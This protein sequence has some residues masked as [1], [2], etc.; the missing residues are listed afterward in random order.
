MFGVRDCVRHL[1]ELAGLE[2]GNAGHCQ[3]DRAI[4]E[5]MVKLRNRKQRWCPAAARDELCQGLAEHAHLLLPY[6]VRLGDIPA[7]GE[8]DRIAEG[9]PPENSYSNRG[10]DGFVYGASQFAA[11]TLP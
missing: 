8:E 3:V 9:L 6:P 11:G 7:F 1:P 10:Q 2:S 5:G 4:S